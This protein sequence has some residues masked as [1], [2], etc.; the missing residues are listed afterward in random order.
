MFR[1][2][3]FFCKFEIGTLLEFVTNGNRYPILITIT[4]YQCSAHSTGEVQA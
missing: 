2:E 4:N 1:G 3:P